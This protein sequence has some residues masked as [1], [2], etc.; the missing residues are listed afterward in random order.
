M[1]TPRPYRAT[2]PGYRLRIVNLLPQ[3]FRW[4]S[5]RLPKGCTMHPFLYQDAK[6][7]RLF[8]SMLKGAFEDG[9]GSVLAMSDDDGETWTQSRVGIGSWDWGKVFT[10]P[11]ATEAS[12]KALAQ[13]GYPNSCTSPPP[14]QP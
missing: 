12:R 1:E 7:G 4:L 13:S 10:G 2:P 5:K 3:Y 9:S 14:A 8:A 6:T 11:P